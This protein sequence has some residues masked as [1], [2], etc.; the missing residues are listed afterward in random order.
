MLRKRV[1][2]LVN[3]VLVAL[4]V[5]AQ[6]TFEWL[7]EQLKNVT[8]EQRELM[9]KSFEESVKV[10]LADQILDGYLGL[11]TKHVTGLIKSGLKRTQLAPLLFV[12]DKAVKPIMKAIANEQ[13]TADLI[14]K[15][16]GDAYKI[17]QGT[18]SKTTALVELVQKQQA[19]LVIGL[20]G[21]ADNGWYAGLFAGIL[22]TL[23]G[24]AVQNE[25]EDLHNQARILASGNSLSS[26]QIGIIRDGIEQAR[27]LASNFRQVTGRFERFSANMQF[28][29]PI[30]HSAA[31][32]ELARKKMQ[33][34][35][36]QLGLNYV[37][38]WAQIIGRGEKAKIEFGIN[39]SERG[40]MRLSSEMRET[41]SKKK[42]S[43]LKAIG[44]PVRIEVSVFEGDSES[45]AYLFEVIQP[46]SGGLEMEFFGY[47][48][49]PSFMKDYV[50]PVLKKLG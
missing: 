4:D 47:S 16:G 32:T 7:A 37:D 41:L 30:I 33:W 28:V 12:Y 20:K 35:K 14:S 5:T 49:A 43:E 26:L 42:W 22:E 44:I 40:W 24:T 48:P 23:V 34:A 25:Q 19:A 13:A 9:M 2:S 50:N 27:N 3:D 17:G 36:A 45:V 46:P 18:D 21:A 6:I 29:V 39:W 38:Y 10:N 1:H 15:V 11:V 31:A 8:S